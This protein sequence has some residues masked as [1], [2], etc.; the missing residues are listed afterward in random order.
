MSE[1]TTSGEHAGEQQTEL[2]R[3]IGPKLLLFFVIG[4]I[5]GTG[6]YALTGN[7]AGV[8]GGALW[9]P[10]LG[11]FM[12]AFLTAFSYLELVGKYPRA[13]GA[14]LYTNRRSAS[15]SSPS[16]WRSR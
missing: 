8:I 15:R 11:A 16:S 14:A 12:V 10:F 5:L 9:V 4:D 2:K 13:A 6:I 3:A 1:T 7:V